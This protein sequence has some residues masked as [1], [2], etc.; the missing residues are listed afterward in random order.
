MA[1]YQDNVGGEALEA[2]IEHLE[3]FGRVVVSEVLSFTVPQA[4][5]SPL[6]LWFTIG[7]QQS[8][9]GTLWNQ[10]Q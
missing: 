7:L 5:I 2:A 6:V 10:G 4:N 1:N 3:P 9:L 8:T